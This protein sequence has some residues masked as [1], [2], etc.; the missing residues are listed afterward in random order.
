[1]KQL[2]MIIKIY[3]TIIWNYYLEKEKEEYYY[4]LLWEVCLIWDVF[5]WIENNIEY[6]DDFC[7]CRIDWN[8]RKCLILREHK[9]LPIESQS[10]ECIKFIYSL[11]K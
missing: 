8:I 4:S 2:K 5:V 6:Q 9:S 7:N 11:I 1:M 10:K 3:E